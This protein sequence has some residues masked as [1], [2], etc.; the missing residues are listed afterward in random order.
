MTQLFGRFTAP[1]APVHVPGIAF[2][3]AAFLATM[4]FTVYWSTT[5]A[6]LPLAQPA[7]AA[8]H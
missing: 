2:F 5:R 3:T 7:P 8:I 1:D 6:T 4:C